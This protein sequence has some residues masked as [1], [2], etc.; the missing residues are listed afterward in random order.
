M[1]TAC[2]G[3]SRHCLCVCHSPHVYRPTLAFGTKLSTHDPSM[4]QAALIKSLWSNVCTKL[5][6]A[7]VLLND[8]SAELYSLYKA[9]TLLAETPRATAADVSSVLADLIVK[10]RVRAKHRQFCG[11]HTIC[12][13]IKLHARLPCVIGT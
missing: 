13:D 3:I 8:D 9:L 2:F 4:Q 7:A 6:R 10:L 1:F 11:L 5:E 12:I